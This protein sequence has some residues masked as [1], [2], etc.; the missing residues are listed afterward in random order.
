MKVPNV[1]QPIHAPEISCP[2]SEVASKQS[3]EERLRQVSKTWNAD[4]WEAYL[5]TLER[6]ILEEQVSCLK[7][8]LASEN[9]QSSI[10]DLA[11]Q[12]SSPELTSL[13]GQALFK[14]TLRQRMVVE[15]LYFRSLSTWEAAL[16]LGISQFAVRDL[17][18]RALKNLEREILEPLL[19]LP[20]VK[21]QCRNSE[22]SK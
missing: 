15:L 21:G 13:V 11:Q 14:L 6:P 10:F 8:D 19:T 9:A 2:S 18:A 7:Y 3:R 1:I 16:E 12:T 5:Q 17:E 20:I 4:Q 22:G